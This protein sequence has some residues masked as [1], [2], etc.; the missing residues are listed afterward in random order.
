MKPTLIQ[1]F[2][3]W[4]LKCT[5]Y[6]FPT[7]QML[8]NKYVPAAAAHCAGFMAWDASG[9]AKRHQVYSRMIKQFPEARK[10]DLSLAI[11][12]ALHDAN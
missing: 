7:P 12:L 5:G 9:E 1:R 8:A 11:E 6:Q 10:K 4:I 3:L 2:A